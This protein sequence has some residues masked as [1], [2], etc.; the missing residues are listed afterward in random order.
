MA[1][2]NIVLTRID[3]RLVHGQ[4]GN[5]WVSSLDCNLIVVV[6][7]KAANDPIQQSLMKMTAEAAHVGIR[8]FTI[9]KTI[10]IIAKAKPT[11]K[12]FMIARTPATVRALIEGGIRIYRVNVGNMHFA[13]GKKLWHEKHV[14]V[15]DQDLA[16]LNFIQ[17]SGAEVFLQFSPEEK[18]YSL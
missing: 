4:V 15:D 8:F 9:E 17:D 13:D 1:E 12:I 11:Q 3:N 5:I 14:Y 10:E 2:P 6:D 16:D 7:D 18:K